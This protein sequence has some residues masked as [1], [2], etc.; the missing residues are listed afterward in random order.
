M[1][2]PMDSNPDMLIPSYCAEFLRTGVTL[3]IAMLV[4]ECAP[5]RV[6]VVLPKTQLIFSISRG[7]SLFSL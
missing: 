5:E 3:Q 4:Y 6:P 1:A 2:A 7:R